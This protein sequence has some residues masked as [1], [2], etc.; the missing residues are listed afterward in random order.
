MEALR[1]RS[2]PDCFGHEGG[3]LKCAC[4][5]GICAHLVDR[6]GD[7]A[8]LVFFTIDSQDLLDL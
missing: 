1:E 6:G 8:G 3:K 2:R 7:L 5:G 4:D